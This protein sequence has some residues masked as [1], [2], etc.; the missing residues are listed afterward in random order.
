LGFCL[1]CQETTAV[2]GVLGYAIVTYGYDLEF[3]GRDA[4]LTDLCVAPQWR[5]RGVATA[6]LRAAVA[7]ARQGRAAALHLGVRPENRAAIRLYER[8]GFENAPRNLMT[9]LLA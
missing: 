7:R 9:K 1:I 2:G 3:G 4:F 6:L 5:R 8:A